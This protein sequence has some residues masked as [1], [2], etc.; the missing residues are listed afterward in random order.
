MVERRLA[1]DLLVTSRVRAS[2]RFSECGGSA[3]FDQ[4]GYLPCRGFGL[5]EVEEEW[6]CFH[7]N[8]SIFRWIF[9]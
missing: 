8:P 6:G 2:L 4:I 3:R 1:P 5:S 7:G 9:A